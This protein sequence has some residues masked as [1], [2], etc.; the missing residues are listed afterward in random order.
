M[1]VPQ[2][3]LVAARGRIPCARRQGAAPHLGNQLL[4]LVGGP[5]AGRVLYGKPPGVRDAE[6]PRGAERSGRYG[7]PREVALGEVS[8]VCFQ[9]TASIK[10][11]LTLKKSERMDGWPTCDERGHAV[12]SATPVQVVVESKQ[13]HGRE[14][15]VIQ[16]FWFLK[17]WIRTNAKQVDAE[18]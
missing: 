18:G 9:R 2:A 11:A 6:L 17:R 8:D 15:G 12:A 16:G 5:T 3:Q 4:D 14:E 10:L 13:F 1:A 7:L